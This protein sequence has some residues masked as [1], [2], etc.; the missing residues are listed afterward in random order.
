MRL[1]RAPVAVLRDEW[2]G[3]EALAVAVISRAYADALG[4][5]A[6]DAKGRQTVAWVRRDALQWLFRPAPEEIA[7]DFETLCEWLGVD[8]GLIKRAVLA[9][10]G[11]H[12]ATRTKR[13]VA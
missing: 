3:P 11:R 9:A 5:G 13:E 6:P 7:Y 1:P 12:E 2:H 4:C 10:L 8:P